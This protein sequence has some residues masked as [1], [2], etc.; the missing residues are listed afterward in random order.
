[1]YFKVHIWSEWKER[2]KRGK[3]RIAIT[4]GSTSFIRL[5]LNTSKVNFID[6]ALSKSFAA[7]TKP[8]PSN[9]WSRPSNPL[10]LFD[11]WWELRSDWWNN[12]V[13]TLFPRLALILFSS[14]DG[15]KNDRGKVVVLHLFLCDLH[16]FLYNFGACILKVW[17]CIFLLVDATKMLSNKSSVEHWETPFLTSVS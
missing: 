8:W 14:V 7:L 2:I 9:P 1:M 13:S 15:N 11:D 4:T 6:S 10:V 12:S 5:K 16:Q 3:K 17:S